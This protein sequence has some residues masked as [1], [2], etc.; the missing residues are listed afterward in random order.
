MLFGENAIRRPPVAVR[1]TLPH[2][3]VMYITMKKAVARCSWFVAR[4]TMP[5][6]LVMYIA[7][8]SR[9]AALAGSAPTHKAD[10]RVFLRIAELWQPTFISSPVCD[11]VGDAQRA[12]RYGNSAKCCAEKTLFAGP[13][14]GVF[15]EL[16]VT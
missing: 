11:I 7:I 14:L 8:Y 15:Y 12:Y 16:R 5:H 2:G 3:P 13:G 1:K 4:K 6:V 9:R 10:G